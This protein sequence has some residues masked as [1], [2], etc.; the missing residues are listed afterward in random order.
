VS[1]VHT[2]ELAELTE[3][4]HAQLAADAGPQERATYVAVGLALNRYLALGDDIT[5][6]DLDDIFRE[7]FDA[8]VAHA[9]LT[10]R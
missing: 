9:R 6:G 4:L 1:E 2:S 3:I 10:S 5:V 7:C 8:G